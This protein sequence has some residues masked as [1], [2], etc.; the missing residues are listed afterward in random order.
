MSLP[1]VDLTYLS[2]LIAE[3]ELTLMNEP[4][5]SAQQSLLLGSGAGAEFLGWLRLPQEFDVIELK[6]LHEAAE[7]I[8]A[9][10]EV[11]L[12]VGIGGSYLGARAALEYLSSP[13]M[14]YLHQPQVF[15]LGNSLSA[16]ALHQ[17]LQIVG[18]RNFSVNVVSKS[19]T[20]AE[21]AIAFQVLKQLLEKRYGKEGAKKRIYATTDPKQ[22]ALRALAEAEGYTTFGIPANVGGR[23]SLLTAC[24]LLPLAAAGIDIDALLRGAGQ[25]AD[26]L[27]KETGIEQNAAWSYVAAR[28]AL[29]KKGRVIEHLGS[30]TPA[31]RMLG[32]WWRQLF[33]ESEGKEGKGI[34]PAVLELTADLHSMGQYIQEGP[35]TLFTTILEVEKPDGDE[36]LH[37]EADETLSYLNGWGMNEINAAVQQAACAAHRQ[38][39]SPT[40]LIRTAKA[41]P[42]EFGALVYFFE[43]ACALSGYCLGVNPFDQPGVEA[44]KSELKAL[45]RR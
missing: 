9:T 6:R 29:L 4:L 45:L 5:M 37:A 16:A 25:A 18:D 34:L 22:G 43:Y 14:N 33:G 19:G 31:A 32:E 28:H 40:I 41:I 20:T 23:Y 30:Y 15:F 13:Y 44:Y 24:G 10:S 42:E 12:V 39:G 3:D 2:P 35:R 1:R 17:V 38:G 11:L 21:P 7:A 27:H 36:I 26:T 8:R